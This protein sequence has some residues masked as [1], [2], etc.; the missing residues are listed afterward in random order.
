[1]TGLNLNGGTIK[2]V[3]GDD[4]AGPVQGDLK[5]QID[6]T[7]PGV[8]TQAQLNAAILQADNAAAGS[9]LQTIVLGGNVTLTTALKAINLKSGVTLDIVGDGHTLDGG[10]T[11]RGLFVYSGDVTIEDLTIQNC[12]RGRRGRR[13]RRRRRRGWAAVCSSLRTQRRRRSG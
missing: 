5:L 4:L 2:D 11:Q 9:G 6:T 12:W 7:P 8:T 10:G 3:V 13:R 1:M